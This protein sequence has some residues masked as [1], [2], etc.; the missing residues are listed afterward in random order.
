VSAARHDATTALVRQLR[1][2]A[3][4]GTSV[5]PL[6]HTERSEESRPSRSTPALVQAG[7]AEIPRRSAPRDD[8][9]A[10]SPARA[11]IASLGAAASKLPSTAR[12]S[13]HRQNA[14]LIA[15]GDVALLSAEDALR[16][17]VDSLE[18]SGAVQLVVD[19]LEGL[20]AVG[21]L[22]DAAPAL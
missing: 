8:T 19:E 3:L 4:D 17:V 10:W 2:W 1:P 20:A 21:G 12:P 18:P 14:L 11:A 6:C 13:S 15:A 7:P 5:M 22:V 16:A 9:G